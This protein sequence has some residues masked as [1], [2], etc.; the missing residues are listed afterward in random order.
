MNKIFDICK[1]IMIGVLTIGLIGGLLF[2]IYTILEWLL[3]TN[4]LLLALPGALYLLYLFGKSIRAI[5]GDH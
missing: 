2:G 1:N 4:P 3:N 5:A